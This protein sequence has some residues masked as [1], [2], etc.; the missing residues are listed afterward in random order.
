MITVRVPKQTSFTE[1]CTVT[2]KIVLFSEVK[3]LPKI[4][5]PD[6]SDNGLIF[7]CLP[8]VTG[9]DD[10]K[11]ISIKLDGLSP[12]PY[13]RKAINVS[14]IGN[15]KRY[16]GG[17]SKRTAVHNLSYVITEYPIYINK[18]YCILRVMVFFPFYDRNMGDEFF[19]LFFWYKMDTRRKYIVLM[20]DS[21]Y[22]IP[23]TTGKWSIWTNLNIDI[24]EDILD[25][26]DAEICESYIEDPKNNDTYWNFNVAY[27]AYNTD[28]IVP[29]NMITNI[30]GHPAIKSSRKNKKCT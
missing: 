2:D 14:V 17:H 23:L 8:Y 13:P 30:V 6:N 1:I 22:G 18:K 12:F 11:S 16:I 26:L 7:G 21:N 15:F 29:V 25:I 27:G 3:D 19:R 10:L 28:N 9:N 24:H 4:N 5:I 20:P